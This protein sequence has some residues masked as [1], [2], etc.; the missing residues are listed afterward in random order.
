[1]SSAAGR[2]LLV[3][4]GGYNTIQTAECINRCLNSLLYRN[5]ISVSTTITSVST[6]CVTDIDE[7]IA[8]A[9]FPTSLSSSGDNVKP[10]THEVVNK[11]KSIHAA[12]W[13]CF[14]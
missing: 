11:V 12:Y 13:S 10:S 7:S 1:M 6:D 8:T 3:L 5:N 9:L 14:K 4:E 2:V